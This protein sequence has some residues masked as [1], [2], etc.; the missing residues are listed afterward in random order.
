MPSRGQ[1]KY[2]HRPLALC[3]VLIA[4]TG[5]VIIGVD[6]HHGLVEGSFRLVRGKP[7]VVSDGFRYWF[8]AFGEGFSVVTLLGC[9]GLMGVLFVQ[10]RAALRAHAPPSPQNPPE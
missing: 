1:L 5:A 2:V 9:A 4:L 6:L 3:G 7:I 8:T 10:V